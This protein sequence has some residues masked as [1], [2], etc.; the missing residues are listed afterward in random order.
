[1]GLYA[2]DRPGAQRFKSPHESLEEDGPARIHR[3]P[4]RARFHHQLALAGQHALLPL[5][6]LG[7]G[8]RKA[9]VELLGVFVEATRL[10][11]TVL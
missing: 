2:E 8:L 7:K 5:H 10:K 1:M 6:L 11:S 4:E 3:P 9:A